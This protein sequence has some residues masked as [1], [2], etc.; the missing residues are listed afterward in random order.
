MYFISVALA[1]EAAPAQGNTFMEL[2]SSMTPIFLIIIIFYF[3]LLRPQQK[4][5]R[6]HQAMVSKLSKGDKIVTTGGIFGTVVKPDG[7]NDAVILEIAEGV[8]IKVKKDMVSELVVGTNNK[9]K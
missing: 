2:L 8:K 1:S 3:L 4:K 6:E 7:E 9:T 5:L